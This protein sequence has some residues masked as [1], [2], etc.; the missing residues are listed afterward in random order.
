MPTFK[1]KVP[2]GKFNFRVRTPRGLRGY[3]TNPAA[4][5]IPPPQKNAP[6]P[7]AF[8]PYAF[9]MP[10]SA[11]S[12]LAQSA[13]MGSLYTRT[14]PPAL[15]VAGFAGYSRFRRGMGAG[16]NDLRG[17][18]ANRRRRGL[19]GLGDDITSTD[20][21]DPFFSVSDPFGATGVDTASGFS[22]DS[23]GNVTL[24]NPVGGVV[25]V[26]SVD[27]SGN[28]IQTPQQASDFSALQNFNSNL[29]ATYGAYGSQPL[30][31]SAPA[32]TTAAPA[33]PAGYVPTSAAGS[34]LT[35]TT[36]IGGNSVSNSTL[37]IAGAVGIT[38]MALSRGKRK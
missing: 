12:Q 13:G 22:I 38:L 26:G 15:P 18:G 25:S 34:F 30:V 10:T 32:A 37:L 8:S 27:S 11:G 3:Y 19:R 31:M 35:G 16:S 28:L 9:D 5:V 14:Q 29:S 20:S 4:P 24:P 6:P 7:A 17:L 21:T 1:I 36:S 2:S 33:A 23:S